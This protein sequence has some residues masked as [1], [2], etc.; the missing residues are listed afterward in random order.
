[1]IH[2][3]EVRTAAIEILRSQTGAGQ[4][5]ERAVIVDDI[6]GK[7]RVLAWFAASAPR[8]LQATSVL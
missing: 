6:F 3:R 4:P 1:M 5:I 2:F 8:P 7:V